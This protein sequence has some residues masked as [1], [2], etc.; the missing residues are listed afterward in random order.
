M[1]GNL[2]TILLVLAGILIIGF[3]CYMLFHWNHKYSVVDSK[4]LTHI[5]VS[6]G[7]FGV[8][9]RISVTASESVYVYRPNGTDTVTIERIIK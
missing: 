7:E 1:K 5:T 4:G 6:D 2:I 8:G 3:E 9:D